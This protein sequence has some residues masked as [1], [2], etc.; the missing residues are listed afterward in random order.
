MNDVFEGVL[1]VDKPRGPTSHDIVDAVRRRFHCKRVGHCGTLDPMA[2]GL[3]VLVLGRA[4]KLAEKFSGDDKTYTGTM[5]LGVETDTQ[6]AEGEVTATKEVPPLSRE[7]IEAALAK[8]RGDLMQTP[9]MFSAK[10]VGGRALYRAARKGREIAREPK[11]VHIYD[12]RITHV[13]LPRL[14]FLMSCSKG[15][16]V[17]TLA[18][19]IGKELGCGAHLIEIRRHA[20]GKFRVEQAHLLG[21]ILTR[22]PEQLREWI[23]P[24]LQLP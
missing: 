1:L 10:K 9:P 17:R 15:T 8:F 22:T 20:S 19:D 4:T 5:L 12:L 21:D 16:Y 7:Q 3:L 24:P 6:D 18:A 11:L 2:T 23:I 13:A 14:S